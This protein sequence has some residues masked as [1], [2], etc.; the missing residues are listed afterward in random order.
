MRQ[1]GVGQG[2]VGYVM[3]WFG[4]SGSGRFGQAEVW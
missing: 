4:S 3:A 2:R 1:D